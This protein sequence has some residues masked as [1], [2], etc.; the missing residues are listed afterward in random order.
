MGEMVGKIREKRG[1]VFV[2]PVAGREIRRRK[3]L[4]K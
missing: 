3:R 4:R 2:C 1:G